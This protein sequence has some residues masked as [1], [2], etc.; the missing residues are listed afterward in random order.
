MR[1]ADWKG[2]QVHMDGL[3]LLWKT[4]GGFSDLS[5][6]MPMFIML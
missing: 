3:H 6:N 2:W 4:R 1:N 5:E